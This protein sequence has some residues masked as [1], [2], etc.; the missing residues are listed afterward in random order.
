MI[1][2]KA[3][4]AGKSYVQRERSVKINEKKRQENKLYGVDDIPAFDSVNKY[5]GLNQ[6]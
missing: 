4:L 1:R 6:N 2:L 3:V 5:N